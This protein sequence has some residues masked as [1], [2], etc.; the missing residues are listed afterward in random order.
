MDGNGG[1]RGEE[2]YRRYFFGG[3]GIQELLDEVIF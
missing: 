2:E 3:E 1:W